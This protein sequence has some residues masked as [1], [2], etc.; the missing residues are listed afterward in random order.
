MS[1][2]FSYEE[3]Q[4]IFEN[5][6]PV[7]ATVH[8]NHEGCP[9]G[10]DNKRRLYVTKTEDGSGFLFFC[11]HCDGRG[12]LRNKRYTSASSGVP[13][14]TSSVIIKDGLT[15][16]A[17]VVPLDMVASMWRVAVLPVKPALYKVVENLEI[18]HQ[19]SDVW[20]RLESRDFY[21]LRVQ[22]W[23]E[24]YS[25]SGRQLKIPHL[26]YYLPTLDERGEVTGLWVRNH[27]DCK[28]KVIVYGNAKASLY[29]I[30]E[31]SKTV[32]LVEDPISAIKLNC[33]NIPAYSL[34][35]L[36]ISIDDVLKLRMLYNNF[37]VWMDNDGPAFKALPTIVRVIQMAG[38]EDVSTI[39]T[40]PEPKKCSAARIAEELALRGY[41]VDMTAICA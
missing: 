40:A 5:V 10:V 23:L 1:Y 4:R 3:M 26:R 11:H 2:R 37:V 19:L 34:G 31:K 8:V 25:K 21:N 36:T 7:N 18:L 39:T 30:E 35:G 17:D 15:E 20:D 16:S 38:V 32:I 13:G 14:Y 29:D 9:S 6:S 33:L 12:M 41:G 22:T 27:K 28:H 24:F